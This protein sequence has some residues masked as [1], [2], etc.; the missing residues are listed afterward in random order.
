MKVSDTQRRLKEVMAERHLRQVDIL[1][2]AKPYCERYNIKLG[3][4]DLSQYVSGK[5]E[6]GQGKLTVLGKALGVN[7]AWLMGYD[8]EK[9]LPELP[10]GAIPF[11]S[12][13]MAPVLGRIPAGYPA[14]A[15][16][17]II[18]HYPVNVPNPEECF[19]LVVSGD[20]M[21]DAGIEP[22][23]QVLIRRQPVADNGQIV[24]CR[25]NG[26]EATLKRFHQQGDTVIL[27]PANA[28][29]QPI[30]VPKSD[31]ES[32]YASIIGVAIELRRGF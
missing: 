5:V 25:M 29:Y 23:D 15:N 13:Y 31:F 19:W 28:K 27:Y 1:E 2:M 4:N 16:D 30:I 18:G 26:D 3:K 10:K 24:A 8:V 9:T 7:E 32:G 20:S 12:N 6:P 21:I 17:E 22:Q 14:L 11:V